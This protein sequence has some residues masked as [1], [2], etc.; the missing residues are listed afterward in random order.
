MPD[1][2][3]PDFEAA[4]RA[5][6]DRRASFGDPI[7]FFNE[8]GS[9]NDV[10]AALAERGAPEGATVVA[11]AQRAGRGRLGRTWFSPHGAGVY[12]SVVCRQP[13]VAPLL[14][15]AGGVAVAEGITRATG[16]PCEIKW[17]NDI[18]PKGDV[19]RKLAG[20]LAEATSG[21]EGVSHV[22][23]GF[24]INLLPAAYP[25]EIAWRATSIEA[26][27]GRPVDGALVVAETLASLAQQIRRIGSGDAPAVLARWRE[28]SPSSSGRTVESDGRKGTTAGIDVDG[29][30]LVRVESRLERIV[31]G[32]V[33]WM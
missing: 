3:P 12:V 6:A 5:T 10:A 13:K 25:A 32:E 2:L 9:T 29:A 30:L 8:T 20:I 16:L 27:L 24:G 15:L 1:A 23:L 28:L 14:T 19:R 21:A 31:S 7:H 22:I 4:W 26:E 17:P 18:A 33:R 11:L